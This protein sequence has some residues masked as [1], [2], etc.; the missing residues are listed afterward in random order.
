MEDVS[1]DEEEGL[2][3]SERGPSTRTAVKWTDRLSVRY[4]ARRV[5]RFAAQH[6]SIFH[7]A[8]VFFVISGLLMVVLWDLRE[9]HIMSEI[10]HDDH[11][12]LW[13]R[14]NDT[15]V[16]Q[17]LTPLDLCLLGA[18]DPHTDLKKYRTSNCSKVPSAVP[19]SSQNPSQHKLFCTIGSSLGKQC[20]PPLR[21]HSYF[22]QR[23]RDPVYHDSSAKYLS[24][25][26]R[27][28][29][30]RQVPLIFIG[31]GLSK[32]NEDALVCDLL[33]TDRVS[34]AGVSN[35]DYHT[36]VSDYIIRWKDSNLK[37][38]VKYF[39]LNYIESDEDPL[40]GMLRKR[41]RKRRR[42][43]PVLSSGN[44]T[45]NHTNS[46]STKVNKASTGKKSSTKPLPAKPED[47]PSNITFFDS[48]SLKKDFDT[49]LSIID[50]QLAT[51]AS[52]SS[53][54]TNS[55]THSHGLS[56]IQE[57]IDSI[58][59]R[60]HSVAVIAN[61]GV[62]YNSRERFRKELPEFLGWL[63]GLAKD[64]RNVV[65]YRETAAQHWNHTS[66]GYYDLEY[67]QEQA[68]NG[69]CVPIADATPGKSR[70][71]VGGSRLPDLVL[72]TELDWRNIDVLHAIENENL[73]HIRMIP[74]HKATMPLHDMHP[75]SSESEDC[76]HFCY[77]PQ[78]WQP[79]WYALYNST[80]A[81]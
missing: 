11:S 19:A 29:A 53:V 76:T 22:Q 3:A 34:I 1:S 26:L 47:S 60:N 14:M 61:A 54:E 9:V 75:T 59:S 73:Q 15:A 79:V 45:A 62:W 42:V 43:L 52:S 38:D 65:L 67:M 49:G 58:L 63:N 55:T 40:G 5:R 69:T 66:F 24:K 2:L 23:L 72:P 7:S 33:R 50:Y 71:I 16:K 31:D 12:G 21:K 4:I 41:K 68:T 27:S 74:F 10:I 25:A 30:A 39:P 77:F 35:T 18:N 44:T 28:L 80:M 48:A 13:E 57:I 17:W 8:V 6:Q 37:L 36:I 64:S 56:I 51:D 32:Q 46:A 20:T 81:R 70:C 78:M